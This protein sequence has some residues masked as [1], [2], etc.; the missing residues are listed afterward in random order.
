MT[1]LWG[2]EFEVLFDLGGDSNST[3]ASLHRMT[4]IAAAAM[5][6][7]TRAG[8]GCAASLLRGKQPQLATAS[9]KVADRCAQLETRSGAGPITEAV[10]GGT[11]II[12]SDAATDVRWPVYRELLKAEGCHGV[13]S[14]PIKLDGGALCVL[15]F[16]A[17]QRYFFSPQTIRRATQITDIASRSL[18]L[19]FRVQAAVSR[20]ENLHAALESRTSISIACGII[21]GQ[22]RCSYTDAFAMLAK[23]SSHRNVKVRQVAEDILE[24]LPGGIPAAHFGN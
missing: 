21:M 4:K 19:A 7:S 12:L 1:D 15:T 22:N 10:Q 24:A 9:N 18:K 5:S 2:D 13:Y 20:A 16:F 14:I 23:A 17:T 6:S 8:V 3:V 11:P